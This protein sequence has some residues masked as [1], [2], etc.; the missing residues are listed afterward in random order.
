MTDLNKYTV[1][2]VQK[3]AK[4]K[5]SKAKRPISD[6]VLNEFVDRIKKRG[7]T[8]VPHKFMLGEEDYGRKRFVH[9]FSDLTYYDVFTTAKKFS[10]DKT[11]GFTVMQFKK[12]EE[13]RFGKGGILEYFKEKRTLKEMFK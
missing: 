11:L 8:F 6:R 2:F 5:E 9:F 13:S 10:E 4:Q 3:Y 12:R 7:K 1:E